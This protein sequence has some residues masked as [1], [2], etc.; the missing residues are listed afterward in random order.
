MTATV[1]H[2]FTKAG[3]IG[4]DGEPTSGLGLYIVKQIIDKHKGKV[5]VESQE[6][7]DTTVF[8]ELP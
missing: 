7:E 8:I 2:K 3:R 1:F 4:T 6:K 5:W